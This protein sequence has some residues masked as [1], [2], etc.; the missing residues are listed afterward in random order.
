VDQETGQALP[1]TQ[2][3]LFNQG[4][5]FAQGVTDAHGLFTAKGATPLES[6]VLGQHGAD[7][8]LI[9]PTFY[10]SAAVSRAVYLFT[11]R[12]VYRPGHQVHF[13]GI[14]RTQEGSSYALPQASAGPVSVALLDPEGSVLDT[15]EVPL[16]AQ[17]TFAGEFTLPDKAASP[18]AGLWRLRATLGGE[19]FDGEFKLKE[20]VKPEYRVELVLGRPS[21][22]AGDTVSGSVNAH[23]FHGGAVKG[24][25][26]EY[27]VYKSRFFAPEL[28]DAEAEAFVSE[29]ERASAGREIV[30]QGHGALD[31]QGV[32]PFSFATGKDAQD[33]TYSVEARVMA[34]AG[35]TVSASR[36]VDVTVG[37]FYL[38]ARANKLVFEPGEQVRLAVR[39]RDYGERPVVTQVALAVALSRRDGAR[40]VEGSL[41]PATVEVTAQP[42]GVTHTF[43][44]K[45]PGA[46]LV[47]LTAKDD[48]GSRITTT[49]P[50]FVTRA[51]G[52]LP[53]AKG[54]LELYSSQA[55][56]RVGD[57]A[58]VLVRAPFDAASVL[59]TQEGLTLLDTQVLA[60]SGYSALLRFRVTGAMSPTAFVG[61]MAISAGR[62][63]RRELVLQVP[64]VEKLLKVSVTPDRPE[65]RPGQEGTFTVA[66]KGFDGKP[67]AGAEVAVSI[68]DE[69]IY[70]VSPELT[71]QPGEFFFSPVRDNV[72]GSSSTTFRFY[73]YGRNVREKMSSLTLR[74][75]TG[76]GDLKTLAA[77]VRRE[78]KDTLL[79]AP[80]LTTGPDGT[81]TLK[82]TFPE[83]LTTWRATARV[84]TADTRVGA[85]VGKARVHQDFQV[86]LAAPRFLRDRDQVLLGVLV[87]NATG[88]GGTATVTLDGTG[89][90]L[91]TRQRTLELPAGGQAVVAFAATVTGAGPVK[92]R[93]SGALGTASDATEV[94]L[95]ALPHGAELEVAASGVLEADGA[96]LDLALEVPASAARGSVQVAV[97]ASTGIGPAI[98]SALDY[99]VGYPYGCT[100]QTLSRFIP[101]LV[102][103]KAYQQLKLSSSRTAELPK[104]VA[105]GLARLKLL[106][107]E[108]G[109][110][111]WWQEDQSDAFMTGAVVNGLALA[112]S[113]SFGGPQVDEMLSRGA[114][115]LLQDVAKAASDTQRMYLLQALAAAG[116]LPASMAAALAR[117]D[118][119][120]ALPPQGKALAALALL[121][122]GK[123]AEA[124]ALVASLE[125]Q[126][127]Q[128]GTQVRFGG[129][130]G[131]WYERTLGAPL[132]GWEGDP[133][134]TT[135]GA[136]KAL[137]RLKP[138]S[139]LIEGAVRYLLAQRLDGHWQSTRDTAE[140]VAALAEVLPRYAKAAAGTTVTATL[141]GQPLGEKTLAAKDLWA[142]E[143]QVGAAPGPVGATAQVSV[144]RQGGAS[145]P[146]LV[147]ARASY[148]D[149]GER[150]KASGDAL[151][152]VRRY[153]R[154]E[155]QG[156]ADGVLREVASP[157]GKAAA[158]DQ[159]LLVELELQSA[160]RL[161]Y[162]LVEDP[163]CAGCEVEQNDVGR[164]PG[165]LDL[166][167]PGLHREVRDEKVVLFVRQVPA[168][169][170]V[171]GYLVTPG[172]AGTFHV[173]PAAAS[174]MYHP[175]VK[176]TSDELVL[177]V[178]GAP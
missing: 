130:A 133:I 33:F 123:Q 90:A 138:D 118:S 131:R 135:A 140:V 44:A 72:R 70:G 158:T 19:H 162:V 39:A 91:K 152:V 84:I 97:T 13:K 59:V 25:A 139:Q 5:P 37:R 58:V 113:L 156:G 153:R 23:F 28:L 43:E 88:A 106:Q 104:M 34:G 18:R 92:L 22:L 83:N 38:A 146:L 150:L 100:E 46:Y 27:T 154:L 78:F 125:A 170:S 94:E 8:A 89:L 81:A 155:R 52:D 50:F 7:V 121:A 127:V 73:G 65:Y 21:Y 10:S 134:E 111:G 151:K 174:L 126:A 136:L 109:G 172:L 79:F 53:M 77:K 3:T 86:R 67:V 9:D 107:H 117:P 119:V 110:W 143:L 147:S 103:V 116:N 24:A 75:R 129:P 105:A 42:G 145:G 142:P 171:F 148:L 2:V 112:R 49:V 62:T 61:A 160:A 15:L 51:G 101:D 74:G 108:D 165:Q 157:L 80:S 1:D 161:D 85:G 71:P 132:L 93:A 60:L 12:P 149:A 57:E 26:V 87:D 176:G 120:G 17:G 40:V 32:L 82:V 122:A 173:L 124:R 54:G 29:G 14:L 144:S 68:V 159:P 41:P 63:F 48:A 96:P 16:S 69:A 6:L 30:T 128:E 45:E 55:S 95:P 114:S 4:K 169:R 102:A 166:H 47:T 164:T 20:F 76:F 168:G 11:D 175:Q 167:P 115:R 163:L 99:L 178:G 66:V 31:A 137:A 35:K 64:P 36:A 141:D 98:E 56:Y 177:T